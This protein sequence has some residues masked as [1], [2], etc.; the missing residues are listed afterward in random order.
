MIDTS[1]LGWIKNLSKIA[2]FFATRRKDSWYMYKQLQLLWCKLRSKSVKQK[3]WQCTA[4][5]WGVHVFLYVF[6]LTDH[7]LI[8]GLLS[9]QYPD[10]TVC[11]WFVDL[12]PPCCSAVSTILYRGCWRDDERYLK[13]VNGVLNSKVQKSY[14][15]CTG[16]MD[17]LRHV[18]WDQQSEITNDE[19]N[20]I[21]QN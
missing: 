7:S 10:T 18:K 12:G 5:C 9:E 15:K 6:V 1:T 2:V 3:L 11:C 17:D 19:I 13:K 8:V 16:K 21:T 14:P 20:E 4:T